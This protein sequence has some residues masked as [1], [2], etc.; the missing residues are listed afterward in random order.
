MDKRD[1]RLMAR[2]R[3]LAQRAWGRTHPNPLVGA[4]L[5]EKDTIMGEG[6]HAMAGGP[7][8]EI[9]ALNAAAGHDLSKAVLYVTL[10]PCCTTGRTPPCTEAILRSG[11]RRVVVGA[12][13]PNPRHAGRGL[14]QLREG[15]I[16]V[17]EGVEEA[18]CRDLNL[19][20]NHHIVRGTPLIAAKIA[21]TLDGRVAARHGQSRWITGQAARQDVMR[22]RRYFPAIAVGA[23]TARAD[24][25]R[26]TSRPPD[27]AP[28]SD[29]EWCPI[30]FVFDR[31][32]DLF[33]SRPD[34]GLAIDRW[35]EKTVWVAADDVPADRLRSAESRKQTVWLLPRGPDFWPTWKHRCLEEG[36]TGV[37]FES[38][39]TLL[40]DLLAA[41]QVDYFFAYRAPLL[42]ADAQ[43]LP[44]LHAFEPQEPAGGI[45]LADVVTADFEGGDQLLRG[46]LVYPAPKAGASG[47]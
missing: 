1:Q 24:N 16:T 10:E 15:G 20:F 47:V 7:H 4:V 38:G 30:R 45:R 43:G 8:A 12:I 29:E 44:A 42:L 39:P 2:A 21:T 13:D 46:R 25:P 27:D 14:A 18:A 35:R 40:G 36:L 32:L 17:E 33:S 23:G 31:S 6:W 26:L 41:R 19:I 11:V 37:L 9:A 34:L 22:W 28:E 5:A 3:Q